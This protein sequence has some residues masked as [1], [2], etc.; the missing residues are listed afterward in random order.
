M[1]ASE[2]RRDDGHSVVEKSRRCRAISLIRDKRAPQSRAVR[3]LFLSGWPARDR[4]L[5]VLTDARFYG[6]PNA[7]EN[8]AAEM[9]NEKTAGAGNLWLSFQPGWIAERLDLRARYGPSYP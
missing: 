4:I 7:R 6:S 1:L 2:I 3:S 9:E 8:G 5:R